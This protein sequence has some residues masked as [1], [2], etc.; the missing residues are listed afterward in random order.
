MSSV[1]YKQAHKILLNSSQDMDRDTNYTSDSLKEEGGEQATEPASWLHKREIPTATEIGGLSDNTTEIGFDAVEIPVNIIDAPWN[2]KEEYLES[3][4]ELTR[5]DAI[6]PLRDAVAE[7]RAN[8]QMGD[9]TDLCIYDQVHII[10]FTLSPQGPAAR[11]A[12]SM[13]RAGKK[14][15]WE[16]SKRLLTGSMVALS[17]AK[18]AFESKCVVAIVAAR[19][20]AGLTQSPPEVDLFF[21]GPEE[22]ELDPQEE[23]IM[24]EARTGY[25]EAYRHTLLALQKLMS[26]KFP[27]TKYLVEVQ[28]EVGPPERLLRNGSVNLSSVCSSPKDSSS[29]ANVDLTS[30]S[31]RLPPMDLDKS[32]ISAMHRILSKELA[33]VQGPPG[34]GKTHVSVMALR[35]LIANQRIEDGPII[36]T[37]QTNHALDQ[38]L[39]HVAAF[40]PNF[41]RLGGR[42]ADQGVVKDRT[43]YQL[44]KSFSLPPPPG[45]MRAKAMQK[46]RSHADSLSDVL[47]PLHE[48]SGTFD[49]GFLLKLGILTQGQV[50]S[51]AQGASDWVQLGQDDGPGGSLSRWLGE[52]L[53]PFKHVHTAQTYGIDYEEVD[54]EFEQLKEM[55]AETK[56]MFSDDLETDILK[57]GYFSISEPFTGRQ[58]AGITQNKVS[59]A[60]KKQNLWEVPQR[61]RGLVYCELQRRAKQALRASF[62]EAA[63]DYAEAVQQVKI[64]KWE[65]DANLLKRVR[66]IGLTTTGFSKYRALVAS[67][68]PKIVVIEEAAETL[69]AP[70]IATCVESLEQL[71]LVGDHKQLRGHCS[72]QELEEHPYNLGV[73]MFERLV[74]NRIEFSMLRCQRRMIPEIR[75]LLMPIYENLNDHPSVRGRI[76]VPG[77]GGVNSYFFTHE[78]PEG[79]DN[80]M[81]KCNQKEADMIVGFFDYLVLNGVSVNDITVLTFYNGQRKL[82]LK[83]LKSH[84]TLCGTYVKVVT[85]DSYQGEENEIVLLS[86]VR[87]NAGQSI[88]F[89]G[90]ENRICV[91]LS[92]ARRGFYMF[93]NAKALCHGSGLWW[94]VANILRTNGRRIGFNLPMQCEIHGAKTYIQDPIEWSQVNGG[95]G[96][97]CGGSLACGHICP[98]KCHP[99]S[100]SR[101]NC[102][103]PCKEILSCGHQC[104]EPCYIRPCRCR[105]CS[106]E[107]QGLKSRSATPSRQS[108]SSVSDAYRKFANGGVVQSDL[109]LE[110]AA[111]KAQLAIIYAYGDGAKLTRLRLPTVINDPWE[112]SVATMR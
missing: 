72:V 11:V 71:I 43:L 39:R 33:I 34:T 63:K 69:E 9:S 99:F 10:G 57:G 53:L 83:G 48:N 51:L 24:V 80:N 85:V 7:V 30:K 98:L 40:E 68:Q 73:S 78:W 47:S 67:L 66:V 29:Y 75:K 18:D 52:D 17:P 79:S 62:R 87:S 21:G 96:Q 59:Q 25:F 84:P 88:G 74:N 20:L 4:Y 41:V 46:M 44:R 32:Q 103:Q 58:T 31:P 3:H 22:I 70:V 19:P 112:I 13:T 107:S 97:I 23:W 45:C 102:V 37:A 38:L 5:E 101:S 56:A 91:A 2:S 16:Q 8:P 26:E 65:M 81:S 36:I 94:S 89:V 86:L 64:G 28:K 95:C 76:P 42:T 60:L 15:H 93:G 100:H 82:I 105:K 12:F 108:K 54:L 109:V 110:A 1:I 49:P 6:S 35:A 14:V 106:R 55:E 27:L 50:E 61:V 77:M 111:Q 90:V 104:G 92:R